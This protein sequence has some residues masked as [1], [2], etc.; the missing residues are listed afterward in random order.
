MR[1]RWLALSFALV[2]LAAPATHGQG[3]GPTIVVPSRARPAVTGYSPESGPPGTLVTVTG[4]RFSSGLR[5]LLAGRPVELVYAD[6]STM[7]FAAPATAGRV[8]I[9]LRDPG[10]NDILVGDFVVTAPLDLASFAPRSGPPG[11]RIEIT[12]NGFQPGDVVALG[13]LALPILDLGRG[14]IVV[15]VP[16]RARTAPLSITRPQGGVSV[17][18]RQPFVV[19]AGAP[20]FVTG[21]SPPSGPPGLR[22]RVAGGNFGP[23][24]DLSYG[25]QPVEIIGRGDDFFD[26]VVPRDAR[27]SERFVVRGPRGEAASPTPFRL[28]RT[29]VIRSFEPQSGPPGARVEISGDEL[30]DVDDVLLGG[31]SLAVVDRREHRI[32]VEIPANAVTAPF[33]LVRSGVTVAQ[34]AMPFT[35]VHVSRGP[36]LSGF[37]PPGGPPGTQVTLSGDGLGWNARVSYGDQEVPILGRQRDDVLIVE[38]PRNATRSAPFVVTTRRGETRSGAWFKLELPPT[39]DSITPTSGPPGTAIAVR[40]ASFRGDERFALGGEPVRVI[41]RQPWGFVLEAPRGRG[42]PL[43]F[44]S[45]GRRFP[46][47]FRFDVV[48]S[49]AI[50]SF[51]PTEGP[52]GTRVELRGPGL[53]AAA[54]VIYGGLPCP[55]VRRGRDEIAVEI[56]LGAAGQDAFWVEA[57]GQRARSAESFR[58][59]YPGPAIGA[60]APREGRPGARIVLAASGLGPNV[61]IWFGDAP[62]RL[63][64]RSDREIV[65]AVPE[66]AYGRGPFI[67]VDDDGRRYTTAQFFEV[68]RRRW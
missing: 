51:G 46:T 68:E 25:R 56:P 58:V 1:I 59:T 15:Q 60:F 34:S 22:V 63:I 2:S 39:V 14:H 54:Q 32:V 52:P 8:P 7:Q 44:E 9:V 37:T 19:T 67:L 17:R 4:E 6:E 13:D 33:V 41:E 3:R 10:R 61:Q 21:V 48:A 23:D 62:C 49:L 11:T 57:F 65:F 28:G 27:A 66:Q 20:P 43:G 36:I 50:A 64:E 35:V 30:D 38:V 42:G 12:G 45:G 31:M 40:G 24:D 26:A 18:S 5:L 53:G 47:P 55:I 16:P 29:A